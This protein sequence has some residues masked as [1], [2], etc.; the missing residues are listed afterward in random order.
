M[1]FNLA[2]SVSELRGSEYV[3]RRVIQVP[4]TREIN[5]GNFFRSDQ[6]FRFNIAGNSWWSQVGSS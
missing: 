3:N 4:A 2:T 1:S 6:T 5:N